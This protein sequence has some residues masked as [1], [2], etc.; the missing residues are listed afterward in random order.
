[1]RRFGGGLLWRSW[2][3]KSLGMS[4]LGKRSSPPLAQVDLQS[5]FEKEGLAGAA[6]ERWCQRF[7]K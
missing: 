3:E 2:D 4:R 1:M 5:R 6:P 7:W